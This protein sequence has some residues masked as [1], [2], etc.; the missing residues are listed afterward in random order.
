MSE[1]KRRA[2]FA[3]GCPLVFAEGPNGKDIPLD[4][5]APT[6]R[7]GKDGKAERTPDVFVSHFATCSDPDRFSGR[8]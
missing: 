6:Y 2:C 1:P 7:L 3:C 4:E 5:R 8:S